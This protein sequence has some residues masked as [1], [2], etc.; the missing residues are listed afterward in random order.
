MYRVKV[1]NRYI[2]DNEPCFI[3]AEIGINHN[4]QIDLAKKMIDVAI[5]CGVDAVKFQ[6]FKAEEFIANPEETYTYQSQGQQVTESMLEMFKRHEFSREDWAEIFSYCRNKIVCFATPQN[7]SDLDFLL[8]IADLPIIK[9]GSDDLTN[10]QLMEYYA[11]KNKPMIIS[12]GAAFTSEIED[13]V[14][15]IRQTGNND[16]MVLHCISSYPTDVNEVN[17]RKMLTIK[18]AFDVIV[19]FSDHTVSTIAATAAVALGA[20]IIEKHFTLDKSLAG[21]DH[22]FSANPEELAQLVQAARYVECALGSYVVKPTLKELEMRKVI[23]RSIVAAENIKKG[24]FI[25]KDVIAVKRPG[26][27]LAPKFTKYLINRKARVSI[28]KGELITFENIC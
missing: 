10:L 1:D 8:E 11:S 6:C 17:L 20:N 13:A 4:G 2:G 25:T 27:G 12:A 5:K 26:T 14:N 24:D 7:P 9:V 21:P 19:G 18:Q 15:I 22:W 16:L 28:K 3:V 23:R